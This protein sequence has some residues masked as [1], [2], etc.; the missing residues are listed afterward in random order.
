MP[1]DAVASNT[2]FRN[3]L[4]PSRKHSHL[5]SHRRE[6]NVTN[7]NSSIGLRDLRNGQGQKSPI[8]QFPYSRNHSSMKGVGTLVECE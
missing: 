2:A 6:I 3:A 4:R 7:F 5:Y 8:M 1:L